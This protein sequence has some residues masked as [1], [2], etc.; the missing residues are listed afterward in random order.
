MTTKFVFNALSGQFDLVTSSLTPS[1]VVSGNPLTIASFDSA[2][3]LSSLPKWDFTDTTG[4]IHYYNNVSADLPGYTSI[5]DMYVDVTAPLT[6]GF[7]I[8]AFQSNISST[9]VGFNGVRVSTNIVSGG[10][11]SQAITSFADTSAIQSGG[12]A[13]NGFTSIG[14]FPNFL[15]GG[16]MTGG[17]NGINLSPNFSSD[18]TGNGINLLNIGAQIFAPD[19][20][21]I[22]GVGYNVIVNSGVTIQNS[23]QAFL[24]NSI[25]A[26]GS[27][28][29]GHS[30]MNISTQLQAGSAVDYYTGLTVG[31]TLAGTT[32]DAVMARLSPQGPGTVTSLTGL[33]INLSGVSATNRKTGIQVQD[34]FVTFSCAITLDGVSPVDSANLMVPML[35]VANGSPVTQSMF[36]QNFANLVFV[37]DDWNAGPLG[38]S[39]A[40]VGYVGQ[41]DVAASKTLQSLSMAFAGLQASGDGTITDVTLYDALGTLPGTGT[42]IITNLYAFRGGSLLSA[43]A[44]NVW[45][46]NIQDVNAEN[47]FS[48][49]L[50]IG[51]STQKV[52]SAGI[53][54]EIDT[55][56]ILLDGGKLSMVGN[57]FQ[58]DIQTSASTTGA[59]TLTLPVDDGASGQVLT[60]NGSGV[61]SWSTP[62]AGT[63]TNVTASAP[64]A[65]SGGATP[66]ISITQSN[67]T[68]DGYLSSTDWNTFN[69]KEPAISVL[70][71]VKGGTNNG[72]LAVT[73][74]GVIYSDGTKLENVGAGT[75]GQVLQSNGA[76]APT[77]VTPSGSSGYTY[78]RFT[79]NG[80]YL[81]GTF[82]DGLLPAYQN[83]TIVD[84]YVYG[85]TQGSGGTTEF[86]VQVGSLG[87]AFSSIF[88]TTP[89][90]TSAAASNVWIRQ[91][92]TVTG[93]TAPVISGGTFAVTANQAIKVD[94]VSIMTGTPQN[95]GVVLVLQ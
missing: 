14:I 79:M 5:L 43:I 64:L 46:I 56:D 41:T 54:L 89:K 58:V 19:L 48:K 51:T 37:Q 50:A 85:L 29:N 82:Q 13:D 31:P 59:Y 87:G 53:G 74:G 2:G 65:S 27:A 17:Y 25:Y 83:M 68:T 94:L 88:T 72:S 49:S 77:W 11:M 32:I 12:A 23:V 22:N 20:N 71:I 8:A 36:G 66:D 35:T 69:N 1:E 61:L 26:S 44:S 39:L 21:Y 75:S 62:A 42:P 60:T 38:V 70:P 47:Y 81:V 3:V 73:A 95:C 57:S 15:A 16:S 93:C 55:K 7:D 80:P 18:L 86:D 63:V 92:Q 24:D 67:T 9:S 4:R 45:G 28:S 90:I 33:D 52:S 84:V 30:G 76:G 6:N 34:G 10:D 40:S 91:G 78:L